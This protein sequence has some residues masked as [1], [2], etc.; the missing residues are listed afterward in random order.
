MNE[1]GQGL[2]F[3]VWEGKGGEGDKLVGDFEEPAKCWA[4]TGKTER[5]FGVG[6]S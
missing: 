1:K 2:D 4:H 5:I 3:A 6:R